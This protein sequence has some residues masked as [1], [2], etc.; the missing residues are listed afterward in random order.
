MF[1]SLGPPFQLPRCACIQGLPHLRAHTHTSVTLCRRRQRENLPLRV[2]VT[3]VR[4]LSS[5]RALAR[6]QWPRNKSGSALQE[7]GTRQPAEL[8]RRAKFRVC[9]VR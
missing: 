4:R 8:I 3:L 5:G 6:E 9:Q 7:L 1:P 2:R